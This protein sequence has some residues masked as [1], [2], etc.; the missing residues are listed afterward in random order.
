MSISITIPQLSPAK[1]LTEIAVKS[2]AL[3][4]AVAGT[5]T[6]MDALSWCYQLGEVHRQYAIDAIASLPSCNDLLMYYV[7]PK[8]E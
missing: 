4:C 7:T 1:Y 8:I 2:T 3:S 6:Q 5:L